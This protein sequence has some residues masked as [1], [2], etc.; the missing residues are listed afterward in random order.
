MSKKENLVVVSCAL[1]PEERRKLEAPL[2]RVATVL[3][4]DDGKDRVSLLKEADVLISFFFNREIHKEEYPLLKKLRLLQT[5]SAGVDYLPFSEMPQHFFI[6]CN[7]GGWAY[8]IA[9]H[10]VALTMALARHLVP[11]HLKLAQGE[12]DREKYVLRNLK[13][14]TAGIVGFGGIGQR[15][16]T[17]FKAFGMKIMALNTSGKTTIPVD[18]I[19]TLYQLPQVLKESDVVLLALPLTKQT[20]GF[21]GTKELSIMK[22]DAILINVARAPLIIEKDL[23]EHLKRNPSFQV[24]LDV[25]W[26]E[27][28]WGRDNFHVDYP[29]LE[30]PNV[31]GSPHNSNYVAGAMA[32]ACEVAARNI[33]LFLEGKRW[34][35]SIDREDYVLTD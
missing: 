19:G 25:W 8:Q 17:L 9:E 35:G 14:M 10:V 16:A 18:F 1:T 32:E 24:G 7:A 2:E 21:I 22:K 11:L 15:T 33:A 6:A 31:L 26:K 20:K 13:G 5:L 28:T 12:F 4:L 34:H 29:F 23:Y 30:L 3:Y 27:P